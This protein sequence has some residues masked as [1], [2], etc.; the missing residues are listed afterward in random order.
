MT[1][2]CGARNAEWVRSLGAA[3]VIDYAKEDF[4]GGGARFDVMLDL[5]G[6]RALSD[7]LR[8]LNP[9]GVYVACA[10]D[11]GDWFGPLARLAGM[12]LRSLFSSQRLWTFVAAPKQKDLLFPKVLV[13][14]GKARPVIER[15]WA[16][17]EI[18]EAL[19]HVGEGHSRGQSVV[20]V[21]G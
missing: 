12:A 14:V 2:V 15:S 3:E 7:C 17:S 20:R 10:G 6:N 8:V 13:E 9:K 1:A 4:V 19:R 11:G 21:A 16:L 18:A 5:G